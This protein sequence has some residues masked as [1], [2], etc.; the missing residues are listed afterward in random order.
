MPLPSLRLHNAKQCR[1][2][3]KRSGNQ[4][5]NPA[6]F[7]MPT[8]RMHGARQRQS[9]ARGESHPNYK[10]GHETLHAKAARSAKLTELRALESLMYLLGMST[11]ARTP[12]RKPKAE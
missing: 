1:A 5:L 10:H 7:G 6:A 12:G 9:V 11:A 3:S 4:C 2:R 8:C